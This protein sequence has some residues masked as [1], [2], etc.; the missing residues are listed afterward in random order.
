MAAAAATGAIE[1]PPVRPAPA[2]SAPARP[3]PAKQR[4]GDDRKVSGRKSAR[5]KRKHPVLLGLVGGGVVGAVAAGGI[6]VTG[7]LHGAGSGPQHHIVTPDKLLSY[8]QNPSLAQSMGAESLRTEILAKGGGE[9]SHVVDAVY[10]DAVGAA[11]KSA[12]RILLFVGGNLSGS[13]GS[14]ISSFT[15]SL[16]GTFMTS[17]GSIGGEAACVP[18]IGGHPAECVWADGDTFGLLASPGL[19][20]S[21][22][23]SELRSIRPLVELSDK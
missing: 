9:A 10:E 16:H 20:A 17:A 3:A 22:L 5:R 19:S 21:T 1:A 4:A 15:Q 11:A 14:F 8:T 2:R 7:V 13:A 18:G 23:A 6:L 12:P